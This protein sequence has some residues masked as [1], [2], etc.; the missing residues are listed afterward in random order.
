MASAVVKDIAGRR[1]SFAKLAAVD[2]IRLQLGIAKLAGAELSMLASLAADARGGKAS[3]TLEELGEILQRVATKAKPEDVIEL[4]KLVFSKAVCDGKPIAD[5]DL[6]FGDDSLTPW[7]AFIEGIKVNLGG[8]LA[9]S[10]LG[11]GQAAT[12]TP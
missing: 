12:P 10:P 7:L 4:M 2:G 3:A 1:F 6:T 8:F 9:A 5:I 11:S